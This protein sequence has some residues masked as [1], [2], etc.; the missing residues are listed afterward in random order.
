MEGFSMKTRRGF[1]VTLAGCA[2]AFWAGPSYAAQPVVEILAMTHSP[3]RNALAPVREVLAKYTNRVRLVELDI[4]SAQGEKRQKT[5]GLKG[6]IPIILLIDGRRSFKRPDGT[7]VEFV[8]FPAAAGNPLG[9]NG[10]WTVADFDA[11]L[12]AAVGEPAKP[13]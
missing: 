6:H 1:L 2:V 8:N 3:V 12:R 4:E 7:V 5:I 13:Q 9:L 10:S 11:A